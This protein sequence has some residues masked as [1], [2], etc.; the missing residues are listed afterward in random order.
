MII[1]ASSFASPLEE[2]INEVDSVE[3]YVPKLGLYEGRNLQ[4]DLVRNVSDILSTSS[5][6]TSLHAP[7][8]ADVHTYP[9]ELCVDMANMNSSDF[10]LME[11]SIE[12]AAYF[13]SKVMVLHPGLVG[14]NR[15]DSMSKLVENLM[16][17]AEFANNH[18]VMLGLENKEGTAPGNL[19]CNA[20]E[21]V[22][23]VEKVNSGNLGIT[24]DVGHAHLTAAGRTGMVREFMETVRP[25]VVHVH[26]HDNM[27]VWTDEY[28]GDIHMAPGSGTVDLEVIEE[29]GCDGIH[30]LEVFSMEDVIAGKEKL[31]AL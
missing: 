5:G 27:G 18:G 9:T 24:F 17:L 25:Y 2:L 13:Q 30:N 15:R 19:C 28:N 6:M 4:H 20:D 1:G 21:L 12:M 8:H 7:Y 11:E 22:I 23:A 29:L 16:R 31:L 26:V 10:R 3:L 14:N